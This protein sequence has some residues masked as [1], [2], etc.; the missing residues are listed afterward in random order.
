MVAFVAVSSAGKCDPPYCNLN[1][2]GQTFPHQVDYKYWYCSLTT[3]YEM[4]C[5]WGLKY[6]ALRREC[7]R[8]VEWKDY[9]G[10]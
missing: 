3:R 10:V 2:H 9:C 1:N 8:S 5:N 4:Q 7:V 6:D